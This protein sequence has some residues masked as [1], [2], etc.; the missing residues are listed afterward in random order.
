MLSSLFALAAA[1]LFAF[2]P[3]FSP[4]H[5]DIFQASDAILFAFH[6]SPVAPCFDMIFAFASAAI[7][8]RPRD[9]CLMFFMPSSAA[10]LSDGFVDDATVAH[11]NFPT[12]TPEQT[13]TVARIVI[14]PM[15]VRHIIAASDTTPDGNAFDASAHPIPMLS[16]AT[17]QT[18]CS[19]SE[20][21]DV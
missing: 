16:R 5:A 3:I 4:C 9:F 6:S 15:P 12:D 8:C 17:H 10:T 14:C 13:T 2:T 11:T 1:L 21:R 18:R 7:I 19:E 20:Q